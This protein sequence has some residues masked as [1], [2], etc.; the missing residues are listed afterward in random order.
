MKLQRVGLQVILINDHGSDSIR[1]KSGVPQG[2][3]LGPVLFLLYINDFVNVIDSSV[4]VR[5]FVDDFVLF[6][7]INGPEDQTELGNNLANIYRWLMW[8]VVLN[9]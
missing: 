4:H 8:G 2:S 6:C 9:A 7:E 5:P 3:I 1:V